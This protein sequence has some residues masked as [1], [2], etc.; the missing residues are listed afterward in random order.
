MLW[1]SSNHKSPIIFQ[2]TFGGC[3]FAYF[4][5][6]SW[7]QAM[8]VL[9]LYVIVATFCP[10]YCDISKVF[11]RRLKDLISNDLN[12]LHFC[13]FH[14]FDDHPNTSSIFY[15]DDEYASAPKL[16]WTWDHIRDALDIQLMQ[17]FTGEYSNVVFGVHHFQVWPKAFNEL[18]HLFQGIFT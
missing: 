3:G 13:T 11:W 12:E 7:V 8:K 16:Q 18:F 1:L 4:K 10:V 5:G 2:T 6:H 14:I 17:M 15:D 9:K